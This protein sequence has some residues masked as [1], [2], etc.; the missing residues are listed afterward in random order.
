V[1]LDAGDLK[2]N[3]F[4]AFRENLPMKGVNKISFSRVM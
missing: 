2:K 1:K 4:F 3:T